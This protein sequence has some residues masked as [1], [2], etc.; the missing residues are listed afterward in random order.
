MKTLTRTKLAVGLDCDGVMYDFV[1]TLRQWIHHSTGRPLPELPPATCWHFYEHYWGYTTPEFLELFA[2]GVRAGVVFGD[3]APYPGTAQALRRLSDG[4]HHL[5]VVTNRAIDGVD[6][7]WSEQLT[8]D[9]VER[10]GLPV[11]DVVLS[12]DKT[13]AG[14][15]V[16]IEDH[17]D[18]YDAL[19]HA[20]TRAVLFDRPWNRSDGCARERV[21]SWEEFCQ[22]VE[23]HA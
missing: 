23:K 14:S 11:D 18:N 1:E 13:V 7:E 12:A 21:R 6:P 5:V 22:L 15:D 9:W 2:A 17:V 3:G 19:V 20:G 16:F 8:R 10:W 4:G